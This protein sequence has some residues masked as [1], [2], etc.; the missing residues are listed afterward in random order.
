MPQSS[1]QVAAPQISLDLLEQQA[2][3]AVN[4]RAIALRNELIDAGDFRVEHLEYLRDLQEIEDD[5]FESATSQ[6]LTKLI[7]SLADSDGS[8]A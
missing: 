6:A 3:V 7:A 1:N 8:E 4:D 2:A 5:G